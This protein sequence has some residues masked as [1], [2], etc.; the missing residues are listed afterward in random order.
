MGLH[1]EFEKFGA[2]GKYPYSWSARSPDSETIVITMWSDLIDY[3]QRSTGGPI[4]YSDFVG[5]DP[6]SWMKRAGNIERLENLR[7]AKDVLKKPVNVVVIDAVDVNADP[8]KIVSGSARAMKWRMEI[9]ELDYIT[10]QFK[11]EMIVI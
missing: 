2:Y 10:G 6:A 11:A 4:T 9:K 7:H 3:H 1:A 8:R 5:R